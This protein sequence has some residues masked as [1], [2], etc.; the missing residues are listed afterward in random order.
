[1]LSVK[2]EG[3]KYYFLSLLYDSTWD[4]TPVSRTIGEHFTHLGNGLV[5]ELYSKLKLATVIEGEQNVPFSIATTPR[6]KGGRY[7]F[8]WIAPLYPWYVPTLYCWVL[9]KVVSSTI[10]KVFGMTWPGIEP[11]SPRPWKKKLYFII[12]K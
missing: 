10:L 11:W 5:K 6:C 3:I 8:P 7:S 9:S 2:Q 12:L 1:M 4:W